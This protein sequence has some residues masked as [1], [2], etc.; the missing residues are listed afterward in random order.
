MTTNRIIDDVSDSR[1]NDLYWNSSRTIDEIVDELSVG[2]NTLYS[3]ITPAS[4]GMTCSSCGGVVVFTNR[5]N[6][7]AGSGLCQA[8]GMETIVPAD[9]GA[10][11][12]ENG[13]KRSANGIARWERWREELE[14][15]APERAVMIG[16]AAALGAVLGT[17]A[18]RAIRH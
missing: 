12:T 3:S 1:L 14:A 16:G 6:R 15:V 10:A 4:S 13:R 11:R 2:R 8:C 5:T 7:A 17:M 9:F 18:V